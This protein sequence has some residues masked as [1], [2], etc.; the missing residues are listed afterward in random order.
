M[1]RNKTRYT[2]ELISNT[3]QFILKFKLHEFIMNVC[4][5]I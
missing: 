4:E 2:Q 3:F 5:D 1:V